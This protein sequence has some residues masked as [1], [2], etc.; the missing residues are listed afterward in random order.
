MDALVMCLFLDRTSGVVIVKAFRDATT[1]VYVSARAISAAVVGVGVFTRAP[2]PSV[3]PWPFSDRNQDIRVH[4]NT[5]RQTGTS[6]QYLT[7]AL[8]LRSCAYTCT[9]RL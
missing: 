3:G 6:Y 1:G 4:T 8:S 5:S 7:S 9:D 2:L